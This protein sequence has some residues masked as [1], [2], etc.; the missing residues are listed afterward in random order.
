MRRGHHPC[1]RRLDR[2]A[3]I[4]RGVPREGHVHRPYPPE[5]PAEAGPTERI[6]TANARRSKVRAAVEHVFAGQKHA[7]ASSSVPSASLAPGSRSAWPIWSITC[8]AWPTPRGE[9]RPFDPK[10]DPSGISGM[11]NH[12][13]RRRRCPAHHANKASAVPVVVISMKTASSSRC[14]AGPI[15]SWLPT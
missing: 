15:G 2:A 12:Q 3:W 5:A 9:L 7:I 10:A 11:E 8:S 1:E 6:A 14:A 13:N 4:E